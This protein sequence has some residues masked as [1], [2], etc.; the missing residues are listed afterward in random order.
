MSDDERVRRKRRVAGESRGTA[1]DDERPGWKENIRSLGFAVIFFLILRTFVLQTF[2]ITSGSMEDTLLVGDFL[3][4]NRAAIGG[5]LPF[6]DKH[7]P[8]YSA[9]ERGD[10]LV[11][12]PPHTDEF[13]LV[14]RLV[15][16][17][18]DRLEMR[19]QVLYLN[20]EAQ[21]ESYAVHLPI[22]DE[23]DPRMGWQ[24]TI[25]ADGVDVASYRPTR[26]NWGP[27]VVPEG[28]YFMLGDN[29]EESY[30]SRYWGLLEHWRVEGKVSFI[31]FSYN[32]ESY[33]PFAF[34]REVRWDRIFDRVR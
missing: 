31:Y 13:R 33:R 4:V 25:L 3:V 28:H 18:G 21:D 32:R 2:F 10:V 22:P 16:M 9:P 8:G 7:V 17:P 27:L 20:G 5:R 24:T 19:D 30:D 12:D 1:G 23:S 6:S 34:V 14:K 26:D 29:R 11:F 15:G